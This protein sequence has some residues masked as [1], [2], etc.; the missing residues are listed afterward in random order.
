MG[1]NCDIDTSF[2][3]LRYFL[4]DDDRLEQ[5]K[6][7]G[8]LVWKRLICYASEFYLLNFRTIRLALCIRVN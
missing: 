8:R 7:V 6:R 5:I 1:G 2:Q 3:F 4:D